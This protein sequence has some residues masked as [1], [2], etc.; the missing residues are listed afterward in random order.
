MALIIILFKYSHINYN[1]HAF[2]SSAQ[3]SSTAILSRT[4]AS[5]AD[6]SEE[7]TSLSKSSQSVLS[8][9]AN[10]RQSCFMSFDERSEVKLAR[11]G[12]F[13]RVDL[14]KPRKSGNLGGVQK[15][16]DTE[17]KQEVTH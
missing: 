3:V 17:Q 8:K 12:K 5:R 4:S 1:I 7:H 10:L 13:W 16:L 11:F 2:F 9:G 14:K 6:W 15:W